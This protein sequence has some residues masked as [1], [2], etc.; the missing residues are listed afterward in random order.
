MRK[1]VVVVGGGKTITFEGEELSISNTKSDGGLLVVRDMSKKV[2]ERQLG[3]V[4][5]WRYWKG[6]EG[7]N[8]IVGYY[9]TDISID[10]DS[11]VMIPVTDRIMK[12][13]P[14]LLGSTKFCPSTRYRSRKE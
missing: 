13:H 4:R 9:E 8:T 7:T 12:Q 6:V 3:V 10:G 1:I 11:K 2:E 14:E 5:S